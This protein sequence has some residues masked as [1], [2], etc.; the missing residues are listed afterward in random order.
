[1]KN[2]SIYDAF[3][4]TVDT[5][6]SKVALIYLGEKYSFTKLKRMAEQVGTGFYK[7]GVRPGDRV[8]L[9]IPNSPS[10]SW[11]GSAFSISAQ[12]PCQ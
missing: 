5:Y 12:L 8:M 9:Y 10:G 1:M 7:L 2:E 6:N 11:P 4:R 3:L